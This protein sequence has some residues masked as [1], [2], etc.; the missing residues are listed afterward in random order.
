MTSERQRQVSGLV[1]HRQRDRERE[2]KRESELQ[3]GR[4]I[5]KDNY[6]FIHKAK[7]CI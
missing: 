1:S 6:E 3:T 5:H 4:Q 2:K 7:M